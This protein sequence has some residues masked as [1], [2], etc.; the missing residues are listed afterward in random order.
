M[1]NTGIVVTLTVFSSCVC[2]V[3]YVGLCC[4]LPSWAK[5]LG[6]IGI[7]IVITMFTIYTG[8]MLGGVY[9]VVMFDSV[10]L[11]TEVCR[12]VLAYTVL[13]GVYFVTVCTVGVV[14]C[15]WRG[16]DLGRRERSTTRQRLKTT[17]GLLRV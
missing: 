12:N 15:A 14:W 16:R 10:A 1:Q 4:D 8:W 13:L 5:A 9:L 17:P 2:C 7:S 3:S 6:A 11:L